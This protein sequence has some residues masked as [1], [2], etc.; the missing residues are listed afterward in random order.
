MKW[1]TSPSRK[2][3]WVKSE[4]LKKQ[5]QSFLAHVTCETENLKTCIS[6]SN[7][8]NSVKIL[9]SHLDI[10]NFDFHWPNLKIYWPRSLDIK[11]AWGINNDASSLSM[12]E[13]LGSN[14]L[15]LLSP[16]TFIFR[17][18]LST[19]KCNF[20]HYFSFLSVD[21]LLFSLWSNQ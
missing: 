8:K 1:K 19:C 7:M 12:S 9:I 15:S 6:Q 10:M 21:I 20:V 4:N 14:V 17:H 13:I 2:K 3:R 11:T 16:H 5:R 18:F